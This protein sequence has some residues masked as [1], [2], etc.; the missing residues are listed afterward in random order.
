MIEENKGSHGL[1]HAGWQ[2]ALDGK[3]DIA[4]VGRQSMQ[5]GGHGF[6]TLGWR[7]VITAK[8]ESQKDRSFDSTASPSTRCGVIF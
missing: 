3:A 8:I 4:F 5:K 1:G 7:S 6:F 2:Q